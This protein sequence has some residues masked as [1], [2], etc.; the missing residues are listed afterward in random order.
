M[1]SNEAIFGGGN[2]PQPGFFVSTVALIGFVNSLAITVT[3]IHLRANRYSIDESQVKRVPL[4]K[5]SYRYET[6]DS[7]ADLVLN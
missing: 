2:I 5:P 6:E 1:E 3:S 7:G 4:R